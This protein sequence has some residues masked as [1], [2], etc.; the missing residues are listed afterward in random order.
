MTLKPIERSRTQGAD[1]TVRPAGQLSVAVLPFTNIGSDPA[2]AY[3][4]DGMAEDIL[5]ELSKASGLFVLSRNAVFK[6]RDQS[7]DMEK[8]SRELGVSHLVHGSV[9]TSGNRVRVAAELIEGTSGRSLWGER[10]D[11]ELSDVF[12]LQDEIARAIVAQLKLKLLPTKEENMVRAPT[13]NGEAYTR[14]L[15]GRELFYRGTRL[16]YIKAKQM[17]AAAIELDS[18]Y[19]RAYAGLADCDAFLYMDYNEDSIAEVLKNSEKA[20]SL[21]PDLKEALA[22]HGL[23]LSISGRL[24]EAEHA[25]KRAMELDPDHFE[26][27]F[28]FGR[29]CYMQG[30]LDETAM[31]WERAAEVK[32]DDYQSLILLNQVYTS[33]G[34]PQEAMRS[35]KR[36]VE[37]AKREFERNPSNPR[38]AYF[39]ATALAKLGEYDQADE[40]ATKA[41][42]VAPDDFLALYNVACFYSV[43]SKP[44]LAFD[45]LFNL[46][47]RSNAEM[48]KWILTDSDLRPLHRDRRWEALQRLLAVSSVNQ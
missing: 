11:R 26:T 43:S 34:R 1:D 44:D 12:A 27:R 8:V 17:F 22:S 16:D 3:L 19:A 30:R 42:E 41:M 37:R 7:V 10:Y 13:A 4:S 18:G 46:S 48:T 35:S 36:G 6:Y 45:I 15:R 2:Q 40:W 38:P 14:Y 24:D 31:H 25:L 21:E 47:S 23:A 20:L 39:I 9:R 33:L 28:F 5:T 32:P 29:A